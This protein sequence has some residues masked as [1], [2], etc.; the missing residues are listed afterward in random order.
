MRNKNL[1]SFYNYVISKSKLLHI[2]TIVIFAS[3]SY[4]DEKNELLISEQ[5]DPLLDESI[6][7]STETEEITLPEEVTDPANYTNMATLRSLNKIT[8]TLSSLRI[9]K[10]TSSNFGNLTMIL[11]K[12]WKAPPEMQPEHK[13]L[14]EIWEEVPGEEKE[15]LFNGWMFAS[16]PSLSALE[17]PVYDITL[18]SCIADPL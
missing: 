15:L 16:T 4:A 1:S 9:E 13:A 18:T 5:I 7:A 10:D 2:L 14:L 17:H 8:A 6:E 11:R 12:C 3:V